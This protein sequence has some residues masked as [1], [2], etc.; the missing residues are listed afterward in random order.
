MVHSTKKTLL[1]L[2]SENSQVIK[3]QQLLSQRIGPIS[4][5]GVFDYETEI[6]VKTFQSQTFLRPDGVVGFLTWQALHD[7]GPVGM[8]TLS[9]GCHGTAVESI[10]ELLSID[11]YYRGAIDGNFG[12][13]T[14][15]AVK[16]FQSDF[17]IPADG[18]VNA[19]TW[20]AL[21]QV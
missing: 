9:P 11:L 4:V 7:N 3:L 19:R 1:R 12:H 10:Q 20:Q 13:E 14:H 2:G 8:P 17:N 18:V 16:R 5:T 15:Q 6:A 21:S